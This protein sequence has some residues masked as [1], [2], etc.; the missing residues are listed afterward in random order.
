MTDFPLEIRTADYRTEGGQFVQAHR[1]YL[2]C[3]F[4][5]ASVVCDA[6][7]DTAAPFSVVPHTIA[8]RLNWSFHARSLT[9][10][11]N[12]SAS[13]LL[14]QG[15]TCDLGVV[16]T[17]LVDVNASVRSAPLQ[18]LAKFPRQPLATA[19]ERVIVLGMALFAQNDA[20]LLLERSAGQPAG[21][22]RTA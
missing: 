1:G 18:L 12:P 11:G 21:I 4:A 16:E 17:Q 2:L 6:F 8:Q 20:S 22:L 14:W 9:R 3:E 19:L 7:L 15:I 5:N 13:P 10:I